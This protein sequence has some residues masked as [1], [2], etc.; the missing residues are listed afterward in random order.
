LTELL[1]VVS[2]VVWFE[3]PIVEHGLVVL[4]CCKG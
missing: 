3:L 1:L 4:L 2:Q